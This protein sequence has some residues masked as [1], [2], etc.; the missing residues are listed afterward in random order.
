[1]HT[2]SLRIQGLSRWLGRV[3]RGS[4]HNEYYTQLT[5]DTRTLVTGWTT[6]V[7]HLLLCKK[8]Y[9][10]QVPCFQVIAAG[11]SLET[12]TTVWSDAAF[13]DR[14]RHSSC[15]AYV[16]VPIQCLKRLTSLSSHASSALPISLNNFKGLI[17]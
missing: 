4:W 1:V 12:L 11:Q 3:V 10:R 14:V 5:I 16:R 13:R 15:L 7:I 9:P 2:L 6:P 8:T 17:C